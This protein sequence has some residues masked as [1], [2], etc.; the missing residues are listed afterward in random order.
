ME[1]VADRICDILIECGIDHVFGIPGGGTVGIFDAS[2]NRAT[3]TINLCKSNLF[4]T[5]FNWRARQ[6]SNLLPSA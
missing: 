3:S 1:R 4:Y 2:H 5:Y 6:D